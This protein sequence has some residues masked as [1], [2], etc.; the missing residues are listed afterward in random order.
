MIDV[1]KEETEIKADRAQ[2]A[3]R[4]EAL[5]RLSGLIERASKKPRERVSTRPGKTV[6]QRR[7]DAKKRR[8]DVKR[9]RSPIKPQ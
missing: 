7:L 1:S 2:G 8:A 9:L 4:K 3:G 5:D 6:K